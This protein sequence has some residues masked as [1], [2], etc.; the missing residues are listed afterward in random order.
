MAGTEE[1]PLVLLLHSGVQKFREYLLSMAAGHSRIWLFLDTEPTWELPYL[2]GHTVVDL[3]DFA[4]LRAA[5][6]SVAARHTVAGVLSWNELLV[7]QSARLQRELGLPGSP[8]EAVA[9]CRDK[10]GTR[11]ALD[12]AG[13]PQA[14]SVPVASA[15]EAQQA[16]AR[17]GFPV[18][19]KPRGLGASVGV[20]RAASP[21]EV[22]AAY[23]TAGTVA[24]A[25]APD[26]GGSVLVEEYLLGEEI[27]ID[28][29]LLDGE[30]TPLYLARKVCGYEPYFEEIAHSVDAADP[31]LDDPEVLDVLRS[32]HTAVGYHTGITHTELRLTEA[33][34]KVIEINA[35][36]GG[37]LIPL[38]ASFACRVDPGQWAVAI[39]C[40]GTLP[41]PERRSGCAAVRFLY[42]EQ[43]CVAA[44]VEVDAAA[45]PASAVRA[46]ALAEPGQEL[47]LPPAGHIMSRYAYVLVTGH[48][49]DMCRIEAD[50][51]AHAVR[52]ST[53]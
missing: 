21:A 24:M 37:D 36:L 31:L 50:K 15:A 45:L 11:R 53:A 8:P 9:L 13:V 35:R 33:G 6:R 51:A 30:L 16:A 5:G 32:A 18:V 40:G 41:P 49:A 42:P 12:A 3:H 14:R 22:T 17:I 44:G 10:H 4:A 26:F 23:I 25:G 43:D 38:V 20:S 1:L 34:P 39:A 47:L 28:A 7:E 2:C 48:S 29:A 46:Q 52:L 27:S 19:V